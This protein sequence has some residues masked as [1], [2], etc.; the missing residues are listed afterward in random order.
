MGNKDV[1]S[2]VVSIKTLFAEKF[3]VDFYQREYVWQTKQ[4]EDLVND[5]S[6]E[7]L[8]NWTNGDKTEKVRTYDPYYMGEVVLSIK[9]SGRNAI[10]DGQQRITT[11]TLLLIHLTQH[12]KNIVGFP[13]A[14]IDQLIYSDDFGFKCFNLE[15]E[16]RKECMLA[17]YEN[18]GYTV[19]PDESIS[20]HNLVER[21]TEIANCWNDNINADNIAHFAYYLKEKVVFSKVWTNSDDFAYVIFETMNDRGLSLTQIEMIRSYILANIDTKMRAQAVIEFDSVVKRLVNIKLSSKSKA[22]FDFFKIYFRGH[23]AEDLS[24]S[25]NTTSDFTRIGNEFHRWLRDNSESIGLNNSNDYIEFLHQITYYAKVY[26][27]INAITHERKSDEF[28]YLVVNYDYGFTLQPALILSAINYKDDEN[29][30]TEKIKLVSRY[31]T[32]ILTWRVWNHWVISQSALEASIYELCKMIRR[33]S[34]NEIETILINHTTEPLILKNAPILNQ[35]NRNKIKVLL[36]LITEI[37]AVNSNESNYMLNKKDIEVEHIWSDHFNEHTREFSNESEFSATRN[38][39]GD[40]LLLPKSF[41]ASY[42]DDSFSLKVSHYYGQNI[43]AQSLN[44]TKYSKSPGFKRFIT[45]NNLPF[46]SYTE[47]NRSDII[48]RA[49]LYKKIL[50]WN[51]Q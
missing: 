46:K 43:L 32:K 14:D 28:F 1:Q 24:Q 5:L 41:N 26:E 50:E 15:I 44:E 10:I 37:V 51:W 39:I 6:M 3:D 42:G 29:T 18:G 34:V 36:S 33:K 31:L 19:Q 13:K 22:E 12:Y 49:E 21:Y 38:N 16:E 2:Q 4:L 20:V 9:P 47:F 48:E 27:R 11:F 17:L 45:N 30:V 8:R 23:Y 35:Q 40:L 7:F 25:K